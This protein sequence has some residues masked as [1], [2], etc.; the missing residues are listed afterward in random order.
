[1][2]SF[3]I[4]SGSR[5]VAAVCIACALAYVP[6]SGYAMDLVHA[7]Q[8]ASTRDASILSSRAVAE[9]ARERVPQA[10]SQLLPNVSASFGRNQNQLSRS[11]PGPTGAEVTSESR[12][13]SSNQTLTLRQPLYRSYQWAQHKQAKAQ[14][15]DSD[16]AQK[17]DEQN[18]AVRVTA[19]Y[20]DVLFAND[21]LDIIQSQKS[22]NLTYLDAARKRLAAGAVTRTDAD[23]AQARLDLTLAQE[24]EARQQIDFAMRQLQTLVGQPVSKVAGLD[25]AKSILAYP[26]PNSLDVWI[27]RAELNNQQFKS[28]RAKVEAA[29]LEIDKAY[30][31]HHPTIDLVAQVARSDSENQNYINSRYTNTSVGLQLNVPLYAGGSVNSAVKQALANHRA[32][33]QALEAGRRDL[34]ARVHREFRSITESL[35][36]AKAL[37]QSLRSLDQLIIS[38][39]RSLQAG[40]R[41][42]VD[43]L[44]AEQQKTNVLRDL[45]QARYLHIVSGVRLLALVDSADAASLGAANALLVVDK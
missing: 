2:F 17:E 16:A 30:A 27:D 5:G 4:Q 36:K 24:V 45:A 8:A 43:V 1:M 9:A 28:L 41:T 14:V 20:F 25:P 34:G 37:E 6:A 31:G 18:L 22:A 35:A 7:Y 21:Q 23:E 40:S 19:A 32:A 11:A 3:P 38:N 12:Y 39:Q 29:R 15:A 26:Q 42:L 10:Y 33:E 44:N 13:G